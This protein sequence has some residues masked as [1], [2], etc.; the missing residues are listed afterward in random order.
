MRSL[1][2]LVIVALLPL[3]GPARSQV[4]PPRL[5]P[6][7]D[8]SA[9]GLA[10][11]RVEPSNRAGAA[12]APY[13]LRSKGSLLWE[14]PR[15][16]TLWE[17][18]VASD[19]TVA[20]FGYTDGADGAGHMIGV[21]ESEFFV[22]TIAPDGS[23]RAV[24]RTPRKP[25]RSIHGSPE[26]T[27]A[28]VL[29]HEELRRFVVRIR[30]ADQSVLTEHW[31]VFDLDSGSRVAT[32][33]LE[34][35]LEDAEATRRVLFAG[36][37]HG[38]PLALV[39]WW[40]TQHGARDEPSQLGA[41][42]ALVDLAG[43]VHWTLA[44]PHDHE[45]LRDEDPEDRNRGVLR[46][47]EPRRFTLRFARDAQ[48]VEFEVESD[49]ASPAGWTV[50]ETA[51]R[52]YDPKRD[53]RGGR[54]EGPA[55]DLAAIPT[56]ELRRREPIVLG[57]GETDAEAEW[58]DDANL[59]GIFCFLILDAKDQLLALSWRTKTVHGFDVSGKRLWTR[60]PSKADVDRTH[61]PSTFAVTPEGEVVVGMSEV[62]G[63]GPPRVLRFGPDGVRR[64]SGGLEADAGFGELAW[65]PTVGRHWVIGLHTVLLVD[66][67]GRVARRIERGASGSFFDRLIALGVAPDGSLAVCEG[68]RSSEGSGP[69]RN[70]I[71]VLAPNGD[72]LRS[73][74]RPAWLDDYSSGASD[75]AR[76]AA[77]ASESKEQSSIVLLDATTGA[78]IGKVALP[79]G[80][81]GW[82]PLFPST[83]PELWVFDGRITVERYV[84]PEEWR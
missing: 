42:F 7:T 53:G 44:L 79:P 3:A 9:S 60:T 17:S 30:E 41:R 23:L 50:R 37:V 22:V 31:W 43:H 34:K 48:A 18:V 6:R 16:F 19:G 45:V 25:S 5:L 67:E 8:R 74:P 70:G 2:A 80:D 36:P 47:D 64:D 35:H 10:E 28:G 69:R 72:P 66:R 39:H 57:A 62:G 40:R 4:V 13:E 32:F 63:A 55:D 51:R 38:T 11:L 33:D 65:Q 26:P 29:L 71:H 12:D 84:L 49:R 24:E 83:A 27:G 61:P 52:P 46:C 59:G 1:P 15:P 68:M 14:G 82:T 21:V 56:L 54:P 81:R 58:R 78:P 77:L 75:G 73:L 76:I 20:G